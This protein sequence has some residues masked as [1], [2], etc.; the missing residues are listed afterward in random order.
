MCVCV[1][2]CSFTTQTRRHYIQTQA[3]DRACAYCF[4]GKE[5][6]EGQP[7]TAICCKHNTECAWR[8]AFAPCLNAFCPSA[9][10]FRPSYSHITPSCRPL[11][12]SDVN[13]TI[14]RLLT[15]AFIHSFIHS[16]IHSRVQ[17]SHTHS[18]TLSELV[19]IPA[20]VCISC[21]FS[22]PSHSNFFV[23]VLFIMLCS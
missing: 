17:H 16:L 6:R 2:A 23:F 20:H 10:S 12:R 14:T 18:L 13:S 21:S 4:R 15:Q 19:E 3:R 5:H 7:V 9:S 1:C 22:P 8:C 11:I